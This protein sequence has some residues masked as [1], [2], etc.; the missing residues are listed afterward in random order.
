VLT[1]SELQSRFE[2][3]ADGTLV[4]R[5]STS[6]NGNFAGAVIGFKP[7]TFGS[8]SHRYVTAKIAGKSYRLHRLIYM[9]HHGFVPD[10]LDHI[11]GDLLDNRIENLRPCVASENASNRKRFKNNTSGFKGV[12]WYARTGRWFAY[13]D[14]NKVRTNVGYFDTVEEAAQAAAQARDNLHGD[15]AR[16]A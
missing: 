1:Q 9:Y 16:H 3:S 8:R 5:H 7:K 15:F 10:Q 11:N 14:V 4:R 12:S 2:Y 13:A 6:G